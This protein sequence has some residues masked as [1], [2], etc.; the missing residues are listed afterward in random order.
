M[1]GSQ[2]ENFTRKLDFSSTARIRMRR[3]TATSGTGESRRLLGTPAI[4]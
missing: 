4:I 1:K 2:K 3:P